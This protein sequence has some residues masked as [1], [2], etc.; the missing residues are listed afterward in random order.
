MSLP[1]YLLNPDEEYCENCGAIISA[2][3]IL[4]GECAA[5][6]EDLYA[7]EAIED[8]KERRLP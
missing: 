1:D 6:L 5:E 3:R 4:C 2:G 7:D 8:R